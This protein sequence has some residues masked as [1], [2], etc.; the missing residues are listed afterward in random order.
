MILDPV[1]INQNLDLIPTDE[2]EKIDLS[3]FKPLKTKEN[4]IFVFSTT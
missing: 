4:L 2:E 1:I 3:P